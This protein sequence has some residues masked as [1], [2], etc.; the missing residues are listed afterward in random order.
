MPRCSRLHARPASL[1]QWRSRVRRNSATATNW[2]PIS[3]PV[4]RRKKFDDMVAALYQRGKALNVATHFA[5]DDVIDPADSR[6]W[7][8]GALRSTP[9]PARRSTKKYPF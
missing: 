4:E 3:D 9:P 5:V 1:D 7:I 8:I 6:R 2:P